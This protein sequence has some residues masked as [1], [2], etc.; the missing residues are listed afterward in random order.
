[1]VKITVKYP[2]A[3]L[4]QEEENNN[5]FEMLLEFNSLG[6]A[7]KKIYFTKVLSELEEGQSNKSRLP[8][9][10]IPQKGRIKKKKAK[11]HFRRSQ[12]KN[13]GPLQ[14]SEI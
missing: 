7:L 5:H 3:S 8:Y 11:K 2:H 6:S 10:P 14:I 1:M 9:L 12:H 4:R 13:S